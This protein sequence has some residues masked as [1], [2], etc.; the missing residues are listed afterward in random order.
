MTY[1]PVGQQTIEVPSVQRPYSRGGPVFRWIYARWR[2]ILALADLLGTDG[3][4]SAT[5]MMAFGI[6]CTVLFTGIVRSIRNMDE[7]WTWP[8]FWLLFLCCGIMFG[9]WGFDRVI[10]VLKSKSPNIPIG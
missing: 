3:R 8:M 1:R 5:K 2:Q 4:P 10:D 9:R 6:S 7:V